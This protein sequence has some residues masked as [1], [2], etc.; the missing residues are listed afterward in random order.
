MKRRAIILPVLV[1]VLS[2]GLGACADKNVS[3]GKRI[4]AYY[5]VQCHGEK[6]Q[7]N[8]YNAVNVDPPPRDLTDAFEPYMGESSNEILFKGIKEGVA[9]FYP[10]I[11][12]PM[13]EDEGGSPLMPYWG[14]TLDDKQ[15]WSVLAYIRTL[16]D[17][18]EP[19]ITFEEEVEME[20]D[21]KKHVAY[22]IKK[23]TFPKLKSPAGHLMVMKGKEYYNDRYACAG[24]HRINGT[25]GQVGPDLSRAG[26]RLQTAWIYKW[27][28]DPS[29]IRHDSKMPAF[30]MP[31]AQAKAIA[32]YLKT[33]RATAEESPGPPSGEGPA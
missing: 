16:H 21:E 32:M 27:I 20:G 10:D 5:C 14:Y 25:G 19:A 9:G 4:F 6:G 17:T 31:V 18:E 15:I 26:I 29:S 30:R 1:A 2:L 23:V 11:A 22:K 7:G 28:Q 24:C 12:E 33:L 3:E 13:D 8:G